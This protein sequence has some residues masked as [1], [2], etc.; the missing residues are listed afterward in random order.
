LLSS[1][2]FQWQQRAL[3]KACRLVPLARNSEI[4]KSSFLAA[5][6]PTEILVPLVY[7]QLLPRL[8]QY[9]KPSR[10]YGEVASR[11]AVAIVLHECDEELC[12]LMI[13]RA[14]RKGDPWSGHMA[15][16]GGRRDPEDIDDR[17]C[18]VRETREEIALD[19]DALGLAVCALGEVN[20]GWRADRPEMLVAPFIYRVETLPELD[21]NYEVDGV[22]SVPLSFLMDRN[23]R[24]PL[25][26]EW[27]GTQVESD[28]Y[29]FRD[30]RIWGL[31][32]MMIDELIEAVEQ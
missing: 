18:A 4:F 31:S 2:H 21:L 22:V 30:N 12:L 23:N 8:Q 6:H 28:S 19:L 29:L 3:V 9:E 16:P 15:F 27:R 13:R 5:I 24:V 1:S 32:L 10:T 7:Q 26:W 14:K 25:K 17:F 11:A 20:T